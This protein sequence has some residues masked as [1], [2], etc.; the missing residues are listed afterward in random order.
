MGELA[1]DRGADLRHLLDG[2]EAVEARHQ[3][4][5]QRRR[6]RERRQGAGE[7]IA[8]AGVRE[9]AGFEHRLGQL[10][11]EQRHAVGLGYDLRR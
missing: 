1:A 6:D 8:V 4:I 10:L 11:D 2:G 3:R 9:Q 5:V 7:L